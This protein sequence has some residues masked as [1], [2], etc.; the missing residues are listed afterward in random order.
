MEGN[1]HDSLLHVLAAP[2]GSCCCCCSCCFWSRP[3]CSFPDRLKAALCPPA[4]YPLCPAGVSPGI[5][6]QVIPLLEQLTPIYLDIANGAEVGAWLA[7]WLLYRCASFCCTDVCSS[8]AE[9]RECGVGGAAGARY[10]PR[11]AAGPMQQHAWSCAAVHAAAAV[12]EQGTP[13]VNS[14]YCS[15]NTS[16]AGGSAVPISLWRAGVCAAARGEP[17]HHPARCV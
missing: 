14:F 9:Q 15:S 12:G 1:R 10:L 4:L 2:A 5:V 16:H 8:A 17:G 6:K 7:V 13:F 3:I 11:L